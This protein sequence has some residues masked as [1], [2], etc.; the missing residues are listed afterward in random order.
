MGVDMSLR[1][2]DNCDSDSMLS[3]REIRRVYGTNFDGYKKATNNPHVSYL[4]EYC[5][6]TK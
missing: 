2:C 3:L 5:G 1:E 6:A 4:C